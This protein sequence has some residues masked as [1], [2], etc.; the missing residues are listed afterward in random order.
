MHPWRDLRTWA[1]HD[2]ETVVHAVI[3][4]PKGSKVKYELDKDTG[5]LRVDRILYS[6][7]IYPANYGF[8]PRTYCEDGDPLDILVLNSEPVQPLSVLRG[9]PVGVMRLAD[10]G[11]QDDKLIAVHVD[12][13]AFADYKDTSELPRHVTRQIQRFFEDY[14]ALEHKEVVVES[15]L[16]PADARRI[17]NEAVKLYR[18]LVDPARDG[19][20]R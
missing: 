15:L 6:S 18:D 3:E 16:G 19:R 7:V 14:K 12:D 20:E 5:T 10:E 17:L 1:D 13:P 8:V 9:R 4:I 2:G 11:K